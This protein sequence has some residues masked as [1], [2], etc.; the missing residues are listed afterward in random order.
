MKLKCVSR[1]AT[2]THVY[3]PGDEIDV[4][5]ATGAYLLADSPGS[6]KVIKAPPQ[7]KAIKAPPKSK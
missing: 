5:E 1:Y 2:P 4:D 3:K 6:F 7:D